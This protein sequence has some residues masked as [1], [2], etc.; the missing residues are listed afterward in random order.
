MKAGY[1]ILIAIGVT[2][3]GL[4]AYFIFRKPKDKSKI[5][6]GGYFNTYYFEGGG[7]IGVDQIVRF[8]SDCSFDYSFS[9]QDILNDGVEYITILEDNNILIG[10]FFNNFASNPEVNPLNYFGRLHNSISV[11]PYTYT[12]QACAQPL[13]DET[14]TYVVGSLT[15]LIIDGPTYSFRSLQN[16]SVTVCGYIDF[17]YPSN[18]VDYVMVSSYNDCEDAYIDNY[19]L[20]LIEDCITGDIS[21]LWVVD[22]KYE[23]GDFIYINNLIDTGGGI[24]FIK[25]AGKITNIT[26]WSEVDLPF[27]IWDILPPS[28]YSPYSSCEEAIEANG[29]I[30][31]VISPIEQEET[32]PLIHKMYSYDDYDNAKVSL[33]VP[34]GDNPVKTLVSYLPFDDY[35]LISGGTPEIYSTVE[36]R[37][38][39]PYYES[40]IKGLTAMSPNGTLNGFFENTGFDG[41]LVYTMVEQPDGKIL[42]GGN[43]NDYLEVTVSNFMRINPDGSLDDTFNNVYCNSPI[44]STKTPFSNTTSGSIYFDGT[45]LCNL[46]ADTNVPSIWELGNDDFTF[47]WFQYFTGDL[48]HSKPTAFDYQDRLIRVYFE[49][50]SVILVVDGDEYGFTINPINDVWCHFAITRYYDG[51][52]YIWRI[53]QDGIELGELIYEISFS[54][55]APLL[56]G[57]S[58]V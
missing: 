14:I 52:D 28:N 15:P 31:V 57:N 50:G 21:D 56:I 34:F 16:P 58:C 51:D 36:F 22:N 13:N 53:F 41:S 25:V 55:G 49:G 33:L 12:V 19:K 10:G 11:Y 27:P 42:V 32:F 29:L 1:W 40:S 4:G 26:P 3:L 20:V 30:Y 24:S 39:T 17:T 43:F 48:T 44:W 37:G 47:E 18:L 8:H 9:F 35:G 45:P 38:D 5:L 6:V 7:S 23:I 2:G 46:S 54:Q